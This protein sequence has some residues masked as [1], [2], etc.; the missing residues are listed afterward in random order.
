MSIETLVLAVNTTLNTFALSTERKEAE[1]YLNSLKT[2]NSQEIFDTFQQILTSPDTVTFT[3]PIRQLVLGLLGDWIQNWWNTFE[4][5]QHLFIRNALLQLLLSSPVPYVRPMRNKLAVI[6]SNVAKRQFPQF[7]ETFLGEMTEIWAKSSPE[8]QEVVMMTIE[9]VVTDCIDPDFSTTLP[10][11]RK[12]DILFGIRKDVGSLLNICSQYLRHCMGEYEALKAASAS[13]SSGAGGSAQLMGVTNLI[14]CLLRLLQSLLSYL[15]SDDAISLQPDLIQVV[16]LLSYPDFQSEACGI[17]FILTCHKLVNL[18]TFQVILQQ[19]CTFPL[20]FTQTDDSC[21]LTD[22]LSLQSTYAQSLVNLLN[23]NAFHFTSSA[24]LSAAPTNRELRTAFLQQL[25]A[26]C[27]YPS[28]RLAYDLLPAWST[29][30]LRLLGLFAF[31]LV[32]TPDPFSIC[33]SIVDIS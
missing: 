18:S 3:E 24:F 16:A 20:N 29:V 27:R 17:L 7:W 15:K 30:G 2:T 5:S 11:L 9:N 14:R 25:C 12:Q 31:F 28:L 8:L 33:V 32:F 4:T 1:A 26:V 13:S 10:T 21:D 6:L 23:Y 22:L 19:V